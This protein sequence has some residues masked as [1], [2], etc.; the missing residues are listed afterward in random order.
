M[1]ASAKIE[2]RKLFTN[3]PR[4]RYELRSIN[5]PVWPA[6]PAHPELMNDAPLYLYPDGTYG[7]RDWLYVPVPF[8]RR[9][10]W[11]HYMP[12]RGMWSTALPDYHFDDPPIFIKPTQ[13][14]QRLWVA[15]S[16][17]SCGRFR[18][19]LTEDLGKF[20]REGLAHAH[21]LL[22]T[23]REYASIPSEAKGLDWESLDGEG[24]FSSKMASLVATQ[25]RIAELYGWIFLQ[26]KLQPTT[27]SIVPNRGVP[28]FQSDL[29][30]ID[31]FV[32][33]IVPWN[34]RS[35]DFDKMAIQHGFLF[36]GLTTVSLARHRCLPGGG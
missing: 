32:G 4:Y 36:G 6:S 3:D 9:S 33:V 27:Q 34:D 20:Y 29:A 31:Q 17:S 26:E 30:P 15:S 1:A 10:V 16:G 24:T 18:A 21:M 22:A 35:P 2:Y 12:A 28:R 8:A 14:D 7:D 25:R 11:V 19:T 23:A 5:I 13:T